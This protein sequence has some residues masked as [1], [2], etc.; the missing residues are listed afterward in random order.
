MPVVIIVGLFFPTMDEA[1]FYNSALTIRR[2]CLI[3][4]RRILKSRQFIFLASVCATSV[5]LDEST[6]K[7]N[8][9]IEFIHVQNFSSWSP[10]VGPICKPWNMV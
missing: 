6:L 3:P 7:L 8:K 9:E 4:R 2:I 10:C 1:L 5:V